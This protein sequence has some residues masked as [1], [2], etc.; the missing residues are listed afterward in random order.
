MSSRDV[1]ASLPQSR[2]RHQLRV[3]R[4]VAGSEFK[5][6]YAGSALG[7]VWSVVKPLAMFVILYLVWGRVFHLSKISHFYPLALLM[8]IVL[9]NFW[10][11]GTLLGMHSLVARESLLRKLSFPRLVVPTAATLTAAITVGIN[12]III[13]GFIAWNRIVPRLDW[14]LALPL[15]LELYVFVLGVALILAVAQV[16]FRDTAQVWDLVMQLMFYASPIIYPVGYL[17]PWAKQIAFVSPFTQV[18]QDM[19]ALILYQDVPNNKIT[20][21]AAFG[22]P[23]G[24]LVPIAVTFGLLVF[25]LWLF[26]REEPW[27]AE[28]A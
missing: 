22:T 26:R 24:E 21:S 28:R 20:A 18:M 1:S 14:L 2:L 27:F 12:M 5:L 6:K 11:D 25:G 4:V 8:G 3:L 13:A 17:P 9:F 15:M 16:R 19:R 10:N 23:F 7:Y